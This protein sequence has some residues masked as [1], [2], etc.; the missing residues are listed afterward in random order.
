MSIDQLT[1][2]VPEQFAG[3]ARRSSDAERNGMAGI[4]IARAEASYGDGGGRS[5]KLEITDSGGATG[6]MGLASWA[7]PPGRTRQ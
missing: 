1:P 7:E 3:L 6:L 4:T 5:A 2:L